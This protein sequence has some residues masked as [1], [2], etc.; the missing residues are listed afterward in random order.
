MMELKKKINNGVYLVVSPSMDL[1]VMLTKLESIRIENLAALQI[2]DCFNPSDDAVTIVNAIADLFAGSTTPVLINNRWDLLAQC[3]L[4]GIHLDEIP[5]NYKQLKTAIG[6]DIIVGITCNNDLETA[7]WADE[8]LLDYI[9]FCSMFPSS[10]ATSCELVNT[11]TVIKAQNMFK[12]PLFLAGGIKPEN[13]E[14]LNN[15]NYD[16]IAVVSGIM[17]AKHPNQALKNYQNKLNIYENENNH[18]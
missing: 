2:W 3:N 8:N 7:K 13:L 1:N 14:S 16:G 4:D 10:T 17:E 15:L 11:E 9:S 12:M 5:K 18:L 6:K